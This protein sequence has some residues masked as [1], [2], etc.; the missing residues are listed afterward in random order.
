MT[1]QCSSALAHTLVPGGLFC[2]NLLHSWC[3]TF[4]LGTIH[5]V[6]SK[7]KFILLSFY[8]RLQFCR[9]GRARYNV[10][11]TTQLFYKWRKWI[12]CCFYYSTWTW[13][14]VS[15]CFPV[16]SFILFPF[17]YDQFL[18]MSSMFLRGCSLVSP[19]RRVAIFASCSE[20]TLLH[21]A[22]EK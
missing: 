15:T 20:P 13:T 5:K 11:P 9:F 19:F 1:S 7:W 10:W 2:V 12:E 4:N 17:E 16:S 21:L 6:T 22:V 18:V 8:I 14:C 3:V